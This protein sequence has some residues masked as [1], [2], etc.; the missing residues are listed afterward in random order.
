MSTESFLRRVWNEATGQA[1]KRGRDYEDNAGTPD[2]VPGSQLDTD[3]T[4][5]AP[6]K[7]QK[8]SYEAGAPGIDQYY[9]IDISGCSLVK[10]GG[11]VINIDLA[12][13]RVAEFDGTNQTNASF[14]AYASDSTAQSL[15]RDDYAI[16]TLSQTLL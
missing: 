11:G 15:D 16:L 1:Y 13:I 6:I 9:S 14:S 12:S 8:A 2:V 4:D 7:Y 10:V 3:K 5:G